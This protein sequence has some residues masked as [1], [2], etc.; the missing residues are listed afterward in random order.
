MLRRLL[1]WTSIIA[2]AF[3]IAARADEA[4]KRYPT[5]IGLEV[6]HVSSD[7]SINFDY[8]IVY[9]RVPRTSDS[10]VSKWAEIAHPV[11]MDPGGDLM[12]LQP[13]GNEEVLVAGGKGSVT[14]PVG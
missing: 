1:C 10:V 9:V 5:A 4:D 3:P 13:D 7:S 2:V 12:L 11:S 14:D 6:P 8:P